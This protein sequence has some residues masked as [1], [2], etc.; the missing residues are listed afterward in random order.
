MEPRVALK[1]CTLFSEL[2]LPH[3]WADWD[4]G[5]LCRSIV[6]TR[7]HHRPGPSNPQLPQL[8]IVVLRL[9]DG[10]LCIISQPSFSLSVTLYCCLTFSASFLF[11]SLVLSQDMAYPGHTTEFV[12][13]KSLKHPPKKL[14]KV[15]NL[16]FIVILN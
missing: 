9:D 1:R 3:S 15:I 11:P 14:L 7:Q 2:P 13:Q 4:L 8:V 12:V 10:Y 6:L 5:L 16:S